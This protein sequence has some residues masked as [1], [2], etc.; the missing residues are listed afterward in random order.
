MNEALARLAD[1]YWD[2]VLETSPTQALML[3]I[4]IHDERHE[5]V[6]RQ[7]EDAEI[8]RM[9][10]FVAAAEAI[11]SA[12]LTT[13]ERITREVLIFEAG[14]IAGQLEGCFAE[15]AVNH[16]VGF[17]AMMPV[18]VPQFPL[19]EPEHALAMPSKYEGI[20][21]M[22]DDAAER[23]RQGLARGRAPMGSTA[24]KAVEQVD[25]YLAAPF[26]TDPL[27]ALKAPE[28][29]DGEAGW[30]QTMIEVAR[31]HLRPAMQRW[32][33]FVTSEVLPQ[34]GS[35]E[36][37]GLSYL[38]DGEDLYA[39]TIYRYTTLDM[40]PAEVHQIGL[41]QVAKLDEEYRRLGQEVLGTSDLNEIYS[42]LRDDPELHYSDGPSIVAASERALAKAKA[43]MGDW[44]GRLPQADCLVK[45]TPSGPLGFYFRPATDGSRPGMFFVNTADPSA[46]G[47]Y[48]IE[49]FAFHEG[50]PGH[51]LQLAIAGELEG[52]PEFR[53]QAFIS[54]YG[55]GWGLYT[56]RL[57]DEMGMYKSPL[58]RIGMLSADSTRAGRL[59]VD[60][61]IHAMGWSR[62]QAIDFMVDNSPKTV[63]SVEE[64]IDRYIGMPGQALSYMLGRLEIQRI[65]REAEEAM[66]DGFDIKGF[67]DT[68]LGSGLVPLGTLDRM[69]HEWAIG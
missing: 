52:I 15:M 8:A 57:A 49:A 4:H 51:H 31:D 26:E 34:A 55:E 37:P 33:D 2:Y 14:S 62:Q 42:R 44:F 69:V 53:K 19:V 20:A 16:A 17:Q 38:P 11:D 22:F 7:A 6:S 24:A 3:G 27:L 40:D 47:T 23:L 60:T 58:H 54:A 65:R 64:E 21:R 29:W 41:D 30:R 45:E 67:H 68:V 56:E 18:A 50:I 35:E 46:W 12:G 25:G 5:D 61:G 1:E 10:E 66:G 32:R 63:F 59:V 43:A 13:D 39:R 48:E 9:R 28:G 36:E